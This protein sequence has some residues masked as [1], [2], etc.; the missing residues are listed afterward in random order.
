MDARH[1]LPCRES[2]ITELVIMTSGQQMSTATK[3]GVDGTMNREKSLGGPWGFKPTYVSFSLPYRLMR[4]FCAVALSA[5]L[6]MGSCEQFALLLVATAEE[7]IDR[8][9]YT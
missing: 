2:P 4:D 1:L 6:A 7:D 8:L 9:F 5:S 3:W